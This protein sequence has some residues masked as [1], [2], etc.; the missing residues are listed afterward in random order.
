MSIELHIPEDSFITVSTGW[1][2]NAMGQIEGEV[3][4]GSTVVFTTWVDDLPYSDP[5]EAVMTA[6]GER[7]K[8]LL[9][10]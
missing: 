8:A 1:K 7:I 3:W 2:P 6:F 4:F 10:D 9:G 5:R